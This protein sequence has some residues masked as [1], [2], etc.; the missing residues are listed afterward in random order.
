MKFGILLLVF[1]FLLSKEERTFKRL[2]KL[3]DK[4]TEK[5]FLLAKKINARDKNLASPYYFQFLVYSKKSDLSK[6]AKDQATIL[7]SA[8]SMGSSFE[9]KAGESLLT[10]TDWTTKKETLRE[11]VIVCLTKLK[12]EKNDSRFKKLKEKAIKFFSEVPIDLVELKQVEM[13][14]KTINET[15]T[16]FTAPTHVFPSIKTESTKINFALKPTYKEQFL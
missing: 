16:S 9:K 8:I 12:A 6:V 7:G 11:K 2:N 3:Y 4:N 14:K 15:K 5:A 1:P 10:Q 13:P